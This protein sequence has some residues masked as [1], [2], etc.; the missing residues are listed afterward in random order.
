[1]RRPSSSSQ[2]EPTWTALLSSDLR[3][4]QPGRRPSVALF[5]K[6]AAINPGLVASTIVRSQQVLNGRG[7]RRTAWV[8]RHVALTV[9][10]IDVVP[11]A[12]IGPGLLMNHPHGIVIGPGAV[13]GSGCTLLQNV[14][15]GERFADGRPPHDYPRIGDGV[16]IGAGACVLGGVQVGDGA[17][18]GA[19]SVVLDDV[20]AGGI[21]VGCPARVLDSTT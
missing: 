17:S 16:T 4:Y 9:S 5:I 21:A 11:G 8:L 15:L 19:N 12:E 20:P 10:R 13:V 3:R 1:M 7:L 2:R 18:I 14:T 6:T